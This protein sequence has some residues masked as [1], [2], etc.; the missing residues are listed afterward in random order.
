MPAAA[1]VTGF[2][3]WL[4]PDTVDENPGPLHSYV[5]VPL[6]ELDTLIV[7]LL[8]AQTGLSGVKEISLSVTE[9][10]FTVTVTEPLPVQP[11]P[12]VTVTV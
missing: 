12:S 2:K 11:F 1:D 6:L 4:G 5:T 7:T 8:P 10:S 9:G 3:V